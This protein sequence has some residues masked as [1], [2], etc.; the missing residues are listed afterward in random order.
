MEEETG[1]RPDMIIPA[2]Y[3]D[4]PS[5]HRP[6]IV[7][8]SH[9]FATP[10]T[11]SLDDLILG[12]GQRLDWFTPAEVRSLRL[13]AALAPAA[14]GFL[15]SDLHRALAGNAPPS[16]PP[17][18]PPLPATLPAALGI[19]PGR[20]IAVQGIS[21]GFVRRLAECAHGARI[22]SSPGGSDRPD[23]TL[24]RPRLSPTPADFEGWHSRLTPDTS[25]W[26]LTTSRHDA[27]A[28]QSCARSAGFTT[29]APLR[30]PD[31]SSAHPL[32]RRHL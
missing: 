19:H 13:A 7:V 3:L 6:G 16:T 31:G 10:A 4:H 30:L 9:I 27:A 1:R 29:G 22:T 32:H 21:A 24:W 17:L 20:L 5:G 2:G 28:V 26:M 25:L 15:G 8:R 23:I 11:W 12:E 14:L 18:M